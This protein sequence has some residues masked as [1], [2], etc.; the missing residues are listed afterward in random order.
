MDLDVVRGCRC[1]RW[2]RCD[3][4]KGPEF[5][6]YVVRE[7]ATL[8]LC[9]GHDSGRFYRSV[10]TVCSECG[11]LRWWWESWTG[12]AEANEAERVKAERSE[13]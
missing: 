3:C 2:I 13:P 11:T 4:G 5:A 10:Q 12:G 9:R 6:R 8:R 1:S 7:G